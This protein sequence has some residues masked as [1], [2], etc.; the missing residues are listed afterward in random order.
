MSRYMSIE[1]ADKVV[2]RIEDARLQ[3][4]EPDEAENERYDIHNEPEWYELWE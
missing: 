3:Y 1:E 4:D 2:A